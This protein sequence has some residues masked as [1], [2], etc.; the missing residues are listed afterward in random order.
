MA[1]IRVIGLSG[2]ETHWTWRKDAQSLVSKGRAVQV[3]E[4]TIQ[5]V[6]EPFMRRKPRRECLKSGQGPIYEAVGIETHP[7]FVLGGLTRTEHRPNPKP[8]ILTW[9]HIGETKQTPKPR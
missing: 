8:G 2:I 1:R 6:A 9:G 3:D 7:K 5:M 4:K